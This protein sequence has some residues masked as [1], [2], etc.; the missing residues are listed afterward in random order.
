[1]SLAAKWQSFWFK[2]APYFDLAFLRVLVVALQCL[3]LLAGSFNALTYANTL[4]SET[5]HPLVSLRLFTF[6]FGWDERPSEGV[7]M[8]VYWLT[9]AVGMTSLIGLFT[10]ASLLAFALGNIFLQG[11][12]YSFQDYHHPEAVMMVT[13]LALAF[14]PSGKVLSLDALVAKRKAGSGHSLVG[15]LDY[16]G[17][18]AWWPIRMMQLFFPLMY[19]SAVLG[20]LTRSG[21]EWANGYTL[22]YYMAMDYYRN[23]SELS[24]WASQHH[25]LVQIGQVAVLTFQATFWLVAFFPK[26]RWVYLPIG[27]VF[28]VGI[29]LTLRAP[30]PQWMLLYAIYIPWALAF[31][32]LSSAQVP[33]PRPAAA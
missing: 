20:K 12:A 15:M 7:V 18:Y 24:L 27:L 29:W 31:K 23:G 2:P 1:M 4:P 13:L 8:A 21:F 19:L 30:F 14:G 28:H 3:L 10:N 32:R 9:L 17:P 25:D 33:D 5:Y 11:Y 6:P 22:Q 16:A 26:L